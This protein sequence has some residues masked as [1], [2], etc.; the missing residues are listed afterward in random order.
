MK[1]QIFELGFYTQV[2]SDDLEDYFL[3]F[4]DPNKKRMKPWKTL[5]NEFRKCV[6]DQFNSFSLKF[7]RPALFRLG[8]ESE[9]DISVLKVPHNNDVDIAIGTIHIYL[10]DEYGTITTKA[11]IVIDFHRD[12]TAT[13][14]GHEQK[15]HKVISWKQGI[16]IMLNTIAK[17]LKTIK[18]SIN[19]TIGSINVITKNT[20]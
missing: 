11:Y 12:G 10:C 1:K 6:A 16:K 7:I 17:L 5:K 18:K 3:H 20:N 13:I 9:I 14:Q 4:P 2:I 19:G 15:N 8:L